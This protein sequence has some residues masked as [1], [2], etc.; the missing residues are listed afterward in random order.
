MGV[1]SVMMGQLVSPLAAYRNLDPLNG[2]QD[3]QAEFAIENVEIQ[4]LGKAGAGPEGMG[5][6]IGLEG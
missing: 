4:D 1:G 5:A 3:Q 2:I 6:M